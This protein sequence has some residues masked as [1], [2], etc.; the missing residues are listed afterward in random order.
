MWSGLPTG[1]RR[2]LVQVAEN[3]AGLYAVG[4]S[5]RGGSVGTALAG[6][7]D[8]GEVVADRAA[9]TGHRVVDPLLALWLRDGRPQVWPEN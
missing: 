3:A 2:A 9:R 4:T 6:L 5:G 1:Q 8:R 7:A